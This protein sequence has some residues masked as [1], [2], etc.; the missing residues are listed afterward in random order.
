MSEVDNRIVELQLENSDFEKNAKK[1][2]NTVEELKKSLNFD[3]I[4]EGLEDISKNSKTTSKGIDTLA[5]SFVSFGQSAEG[6]LVK[7]A[8]TITIV[9]EAITAMV[10]TIS[11]AISMLTDKISELTLDQVGAGFDKYAEKTRS[12]QTIMAATRKEGEAESDAMERVN[13]QVSKL[14]W[15]SDETSFRLNDMTDA[16]S[17]FTSNNIGLEESIVSIMGISTACGL[18]GTSIANAA[19]AQQGF[20]KA[21]GR[22]Y[23]T[24]QNWNWVESARLG[25]AQFKEELIAAGLA[26][27][28]LEEVNGKI[29]AKMTSEENRKKA[30]YE[31]TVSNFK[32]TLK[33]QWLNNDAMQIALSEYG[34]FAEKAA[35]LYSISGEKMLASDLIEWTTG[36]N[37]GTMNLQEIQKD[38]ATNPYY[39]YTAEEIREMLPLIEELG[40]D[41]YNLG[42]KAFAASQEAKTF[43]E[44]MESITDAASTKWMRIF[45][46]LIGDYVEAKKIWTAFAQWGYNVFVAPLDLITSGMNKWREAG[47]WDMLFGNN[48]E[49]AVYRL[50]GAL[51]SWLKPIRMIMVDLG[52]LESADAGTIIDGI[53]GNSE[54]LGDFFMKIT[55]KVSEFVDGLYMS[56]GLANSIYGVLKLI[57]GIFSIFKTFFGVAFNSLKTI[58]TSL[59]PTVI[60]IAGKIADFFSN[61]ADK[62]S[63][64]LAN[65]NIL[66]AVFNALSTAAS[67]LLS[68]I[69]SLVEKFTS[70][71]V[72]TKL[73][74]DLKNIFIAIS[75]AI[76]SA[77]DAVTK[78]WKELNVGERISNA[79]ATAIGIIVSLVKKAIKLAKKII[80]ALT[81]VIKFLK[82]KALAV[83]NTV[84]SALSGFFNEKWPR[85]AQIFKS[86][87][88][89]ISSTFHNTFEDINGLIQAIKEKSLG[90]VLSEWIEGIKE[91][92]KGTIDG[93]EESRFYQSLKGWYERTILPVWNWITGLFA[94]ISGFFKKDE[95][96]VSQF[97][98]VLNTVFEYLKNSNLIKILGLVAGIII[99]FKK[100]SEISGGNAFYNTIES[101]FSNMGGAFSSIK[102][103]FTNL[104]MNRF[105]SNV[106]A[107]AVAIA[108]V[109][110]AIKKIAEIDTDELW[111]A[112]GVVAVIGVILGGLSVALTWAGGK[113]GG[114]MGTVMNLST[115][116]KLLVFAVG[117][118]LMVGALRLIANIIKDLAEVPNVEQAGKIVSKIIG[119]M[120]ALV[121]A[122]AFAIPIFQSLNYLGGAI[123]K[124]ALGMII[125]ASIPLQQF[126]NGLGALVAVV[127][128]I[129]LASIAIL[130]LLKSVAIAD[131]AQ[132]GLMV[133]KVFGVVLVMLALAAAILPFALA[134]FL[135]SMVKPKALWNAVGAVSVIMF[136]LGAITSMIMSSLGKKTA[137]SPKQL[138]AKTLQIVALAF[139]MLSLSVAMD[140]LLIG[141]IA[142]AAVLNRFPDIQKT[143]WTAVAIV[144]GLL[145]AI[146]FFAKLSTSGT[147]GVQMRGVGVMLIGVAALIAAIAVVAIIVGTLPEDQLNNV[148]RAMVLLA[149][150]VVALGYLF[151]NIK[152]VSF[153]EAGV[154]VACIGALLAIGYALSLLKGVEVSNLIVGGLTMLGFVLVLSMLVKAISKLSTSIGG[155]LGAGTA[156]KK[157]LGGLSL[158]IL[159]LGASMVGIGFSFKLMKGINLGTMIVGAITMLGFVALL[160]PLIKTIGKLANTLNVGG[161]FKPAKRITDIV[162][163]L[164]VMIVALGA[165]MVGIGFGLSLIANVPLDNLEIGLAAMAAFM[166]FLSIIIGILMNSKQ[167]SN[168]MT[169]ENLLAVSL[170]IAA[171]GASFVALCYGLQMLSSI[172]WDTLGKGGAVLGALVVALVVL[173][174]VAE[175]F[176][177]GAGALAGIIIAIGVAALLC[178][179]GMIALAFGLA[180]LEEVFPNI[181]LY[182]GSFLGVIEDNVWGVLLFSVAAGAIVGIL[183]AVAVVILAAAVAGLIL[184]AAVLVVAAAIAIVV[185][186]LGLFAKNGEKVKG[187]LIALGQGLAG[188]AEAV[189]GHLWTLFELGLVFLLVAADVIIIAVAIAIV[190]IAL[191]V[192]MALATGFLAL[193]A[194]FPD[195]ITK[196]GDAIAGLSTK[197]DE[198]KSG[199]EV[200][201]GIAGI[202]ALIG[203]ALI[204]LGIG[205]I[206]AGAGIGLLWPPLI[207]LAIAVMVCASALDKTSGSL[208]LFG[209][210]FKN[211]LTEIKSAGEG[212]SIEDL[213]IFKIM[214]ELRKASRGSNVKY[215][216][217]ITQSIAEIIHYTNEIDT[218]KF[219]TKIDEAAEGLKKL[220]NSYAEIA[221]QLAKVEVDPLA[222][223]EAVDNIKDAMDILAED[224]TGAAEA[225]DG[226]LNGGDMLKNFDVQSIMDGID[227]EGILG[228]VK[229]MMSNL[230]NGGGE[231]LLTS[232]FSKIKG[233]GGSGSGGIM[234]MIT[235]VFS[236]SEAAPATEAAAQTGT[237]VGNSMADGVATAVGS[238]ENKAK[239]QDSLMSLFGIGGDG[240]FDLASLTGNSDL[241]SM[242]G[243]ID[244]SGFSSSMTISDADKEKFAKSAKDA[245]KKVADA[246]ADPANTKAAKASASN[247][248][249]T[250]V[251]ELKAGYNDFYNAGLS[252]GKAYLA[253]Y[254]AASDINSPSKEMIKRAAYMVE[255][256]TKSIKVE[257]KGFTNSGIDS[258]KAFLDPF[259]Q[260]LSVVDSYLESDM[261]RTLTI[262]PVVDMSNV[263]SASSL[264][265]QGLNTSATIGYAGDAAYSRRSLQNIQNE[266]GGSVGQQTVVNLTVTQPSEAWTEHLFNR[267]NVKFGGLV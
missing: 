154:I 11:G 224:R 93:L 218:T 51:Q 212:W 97:G 32:N 186:A 131:K 146:G 81:P 13:E 120:A 188:L 191:G 231:S 256:F 206:I 250:A 14:N 137:L 88:G 89:A 132:L 147:G 134:A 254:D 17:K 169:G 232:L 46:L 168:A 20:S 38:L 24:A 178:G 8:A 74:E 111:V 30:E 104:T 117:I 246:I 177:L 209:T 106:L 105:A 5:T 124:L 149:L 119:S 219:S 240:S 12:V 182:F 223:R 82:D 80:T 92:L 121:A 109:A 69:T 28:T 91:S 129:A 96:G 66:E 205:A 139:F 41:E 195:S 239:V 29:F 175:Y 220:A 187:A 227:W 108:L 259:T 31:V 113:I 255:G 49:G 236:P 59:L 193:L 52:Y 248:V 183:V 210:S 181:I 194:L 138:A 180:L 166:L 179:V 3:K 130:A 36:L 103:F 253:G 102:T 163:S 101:A 1:S 60:M 73:F 83:F 87:W 252:N 247:I 133:G 176:S 170:A 141:V 167:M 84:S 242:M 190:V 228:K 95:T 152:G 50:G 221:T 143:I 142:L 86:I 237:E 249:N 55:T 54:R 234:G 21:I 16:V 225:D 9:H 78:W 251:S 160:I 33:E 10:D 44:A 217:T 62:I 64:V 19:H 196:I 43:S 47:G 110:L 45:E 207:G 267:F 127:A 90:G 67:F 114:A 203:A 125:F 144:A 263:A 39:D 222:F 75:E 258:A 198:I 229:E 161:D 94:K 261:D 18:A 71:E 118:Y 140:I 148:I 260:T 171:L 211:M 63:N 15:F 57:G 112:V 241:K 189:K 56:D 197:V 65:T 70:G 53:L 34:T 215:L 116:A 238:E 48:Q 243:N 107:F 58:S 172:S 136:V 72:G 200:L 159:A 162:N 174:V 235:G 135:L 77:I 262:T 266:S 204:V 128:V 230:G 173:M 98:T 27:G 26:V 153:K 199:I 151:K 126:V 164:S 123:L 61:V 35:E 4:G 226:W 192:L 155:S 79:I 165:A 184:S 76:N 245:G 158:V 68:I 100:I 2:I 115:I 37:E 150:V 85:I 216:A 264:I 157:T 201:K 122:L 23:M 257:E 244:T 22:G 208:E 6:S 213:G 42:R 214:N 156:M 233:D 265:S 202:I 185:I 40:D 7:T 25:T 99:A 145:V